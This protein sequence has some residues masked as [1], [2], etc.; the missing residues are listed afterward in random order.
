MGYNRQ[1]HAYKLNSHL[2]TSHLIPPAAERW[3]SVLTQGC[4]LRLCASAQSL[5]QG[6]P[7]AVTQWNSILN[8]HM[9]FRT[10]GFEAL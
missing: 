7:I 4:I 9:V 5:Q 3:H 10:G 1:A 8:T 2:H 6:F